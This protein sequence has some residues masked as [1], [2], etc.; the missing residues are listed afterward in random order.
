MVEILRMQRADIE[1][2]KTLTDIERW[3]HLEEDFERFSALDPDGCYVAWLGGER[4]GVITSATYGGYSFLGNLI[5]RRDFRG[6]GIGIKLMEKML[7][8]LDGKGVKT[9]ELDGVFRAVEA[10]RT[11]GFRDK[12]L[13]LRFLRPASKE[14]CCIQQPKRSC[15]L[16]IEEI[17]R[18][19]REKTGIDRSMFLEHLLK[20][21][22]HTTYVLD[23][24]EI[25]AYAVVRERANGFRH[26]GPL[27]AG[28]DS[29]ASDLTACISEENACADLTVG[30]PCINSSMQQIVVQCGFLHRPPSLR[31]YRG[32]RIKYEQSVYAIISADAG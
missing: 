17:L 24:K 14:P 27:V 31:M 30:I 1:F 32:Q 26:I 5:V 23:P 25:K 29:A 15:G 20:G 19:D 28:D 21:H 6:K 7:T 4:V 12:Y 16:N 2:A 18:F 13:S 22:P 11:M 8:H 3:G 10:Y 9:I